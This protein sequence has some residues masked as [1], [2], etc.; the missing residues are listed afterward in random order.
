[1]AAR[2]TSWLMAREGILTNFQKTWMV[3]NSR[4]IWYELDWKSPIQNFF[5]PYPDGWILDANTA[6]NF[7]TKK[8][9]IFANFL[10]LKFFF[11]YFSLQ[12]RKLIILFTTKINLSFVIVT[13]L[14]VS[15]SIWHS[16]FLKKFFFEFSALIDI[17]KIPVYLNKFGDESLR[18]L[19]RRVCYRHLIV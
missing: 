6:L 13:T 11:P 16:N 12:Y 1:M 17:E 2:V 7:L 10:I 15:H 14:F 8:N 5:S 4:S 18:E 19:I 3:C 9:Y